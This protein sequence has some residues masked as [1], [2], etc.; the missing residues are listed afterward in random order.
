MFK[1]EVDSR[2][3]GCAPRRSDECPGR[4]G[5][6]AKKDGS[7]GGKKKV[8]NQITATEKS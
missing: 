5:E 3:G 1:R 8:I 7:H 6:K 2:W 4:R